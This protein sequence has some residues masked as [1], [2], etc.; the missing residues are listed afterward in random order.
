M[1][2]LPVLALVVILAA[3]ISCDP[4]GGDTYSSPEFDAAVANCEQTIRAEAENPQSVSFGQILHDYVEVRPFPNS[5][6]IYGEFT[7][8]VGDRVL[9]PHFYWC[10]VGMGEIS[11]LDIF[12]G[13]AADVD[14]AASR[15]K[16][17][18][19][20][21]QRSEFPDR[22]DFDSYGPNS[23]WGTLPYWKIQGTVGLMNSSGEMIPYNYYCDIEHGKILGVRLTE[24]D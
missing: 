23:D 4:I 12:T 22:A 10:V 18:W 15:V 14:N 6:E 5:W 7:Q 19:A 9:A 17:Q 3:L 2:K 21:A 11:T 13:H 20:I 8:A 1:I 24:A 16:C